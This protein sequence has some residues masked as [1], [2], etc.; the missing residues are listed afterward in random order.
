MT[1]PCAHTMLDLFPPDP[2]K[3]K[4]IRLDIK[5]YPFMDKGYDVVY[6]NLF[7]PTGTWRYIELI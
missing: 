6:E 4:K 7:L 1:V 2:S 5:K 3:T